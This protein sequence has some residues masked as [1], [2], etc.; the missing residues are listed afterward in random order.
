MVMWKRAS[1]DGSGTCRRTDDTLMSNRQTET[2]IARYLDAVNAHDIEAMNACL[3]D[4]VI[5]DV[6]QGSREI[7]KEKF[8]WFMA[9]RMRHFDEQLS[10]IVI[11]T[12]ASGTRAAAEFT[13]R[14]TY[15]AT[16]DGFPPANG[17]RYSYAAGLFFDVEDG[18][19]TRLTS[20][21]NRAELL[22]A[23]ER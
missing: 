14:G 21:F 13:V 2:L 4:D 17:Q 12:D 3:D 9:M 22:A 8:R 6:N 19:I 20:C 23:L 5:H 16:A 1:A 18:E 15:R 11:M 7:G 10:D